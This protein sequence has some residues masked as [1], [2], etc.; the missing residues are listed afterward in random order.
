MKQVLRAAAVAGCAMVAGL[1]AQQPTFRA[2][3]DLVRVFV[4]VTDRDGRLVTTLPQS[5]FEIRDNGRPQ[6]IV[7]FDNQPQPIQLVVMLD[8][9]G[10]MQGNLPLLREAS[11]Q[12]FTRLLPEDVARVGTFGQEVL[13]SD[14]FTNDRGALAA[15][16]PETI[17][18]NAG[19]PLWR[20]LGQAIDTFGPADGSVR[21]VVLVLSDGRDSGAGR[22]SQAEIIDRARDRDVM[23]YAVGMR[24]RS[25]GAPQIGFGSGGLMSTLAADMPDRGLALAAEH[26]GGG[27][28]ELRG[29]MDLGAAF[30]AVADELHRQYLIGYALPARDGRV[31]EIDVRVSERGLTPRARRE[32]R[33]PGGN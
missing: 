15:A 3:E 33:A 25:G 18:P 2:G 9:S 1:S 26:T 23:I 30:A 5:V 27:Y 32:Y 13:I 10:S 8:V 11:V 16:L 6:P 21:R 7:V 31:H 24:S 22:P 29:N 28:L 17:A 12:L 4:T 19:T 14:T 20:A